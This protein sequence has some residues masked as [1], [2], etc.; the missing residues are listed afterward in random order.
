MRPCQAQKETRRSRLPHNETMPE[1]MQA[2][3]AAR[4]WNLIAGRAD[5]RCMT[6]QS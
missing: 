6:R 2:T 4:N 1:W 5:G 3:L